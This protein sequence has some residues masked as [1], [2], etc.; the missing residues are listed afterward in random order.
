MQAATGL[1]GQDWGGGRSWCPDRPGT[2]TALLSTC[3]P[4]YLALVFFLLTHLTGLVWPLSVSPTQQILFYADLQQAIPGRKLA[5]WSTPP[6]PPP[7]PQPAWYTEDL[8]QKGTAPLQC[9]IP[10]IVVLL[11]GLDQLL[12][13]FWTQIRCSSPYSLDMPAPLNS[14]WTQKYCERGWSSVAPGTDRFSAMRVTQSVVVEWL[15]GLDRVSTSQ[16]PNLKTVSTHTH[17]IR[18]LKYKKYF[19][20]YI[21]IIKLYFSFTLPFLFLVPTLQIICWPLPW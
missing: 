7:P 9:F 8:H 15:Q 14:L 13:D 4:H 17:T 10:L 12:P 16:F 20:K 5:D 6:P 18:T 21:K 11:R 19:F 3:H 1:V 2:D